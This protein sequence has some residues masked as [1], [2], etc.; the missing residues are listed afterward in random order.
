LAVQAGDGRRAEGVP[1]EPEQGGDAQEAVLD[2]LEQSVDVAERQ[3]DQ[4]I[5]SCAGVCV[6]RARTPKHPARL[7]AD[8][9]GRLRPRTL[10]YTPGCEAMSNDASEIDPSVPP[11]GTRCAECLGGEG[12]GWWLHLRRCAACGHIGC[13]DTS[14]SQH[15]TAHYE[16]EGHPILASFEPGEEWFYD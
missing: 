16:A 14:P 8:R 9:G 10:A 4:V 6:R 12:P 1:A 2:L 7:R 15:A 5:G 13:C 3:A 11:S